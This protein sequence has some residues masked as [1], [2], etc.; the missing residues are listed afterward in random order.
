MTPFT[1]EISLPVLKH[2]SP[3][4]LPISPPRHLCVKIARGA[5]G[6]KIPELGGGGVVLKWAHK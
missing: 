2:L 4:R 6:F 3:L 1:R 5:A